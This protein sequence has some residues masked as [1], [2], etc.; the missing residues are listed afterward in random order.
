[1]LPN[2]CLSDLERAGLRELREAEWE[3]VGHFLEL[4]DPR[5][6]VEGP[7]SIAELPIFG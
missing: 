7:P 2:D 4:K 5:V 3:M 1:M 6:L